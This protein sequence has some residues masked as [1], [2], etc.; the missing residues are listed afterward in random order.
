MEVKDVRASREDEV[1]V[2]RVGCLC[3]SGH[4]R[5]VAFA[6]RLG[7]V[8]WCGKDGDGDGKG[9]GGWDVRVRHRD[10]TRGV[11]EMK[12]VRWEKGRRKEMEKQGDEEKMDGQREEC[13]RNED[14]EGD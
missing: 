5:S 1:A 3:G 9:Q 13:D 7:K 8:R 14:S 10:L 12:R 6:E 4:H 2:L 11:E